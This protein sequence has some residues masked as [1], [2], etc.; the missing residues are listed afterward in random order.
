MPEHLADEE[1]VSVGLEMEAAGEVAAFGPERVPCTGLN[2]RQHPGAVQAGELHAAHTFLSSQRGEH[3]EEW[4]SGGE[5]GITEGG[6]DEDRR[7]RRVGDDVPKHLEAR[8]VR[9]LEVIEHEDEGVRGRHMLEEPGHGAVQEVAL[10]VG[11]RAHR[12]RDVAQ[13][14]AETGHDARQLPAVDRGMAFEFE[15][16]GVSDVVRKCLDEETV[17]DAEVLF[18]TSEEHDRTHFVGREGHLGLERGLAHSR[19]AGKEDHPASVA[20]DCTLQSLQESSGLRFA[21]DDAD[22][23][24]GLEAEGQGHPLR[25]QLVARRFPGHL[26][27]EHRVAQAL[28]GDFAQR[29]EAVGCSAPRRRPDQV[30]REDLAAI[31]LGAQPRRLDD[32]IAVVVTAFEGGLSRA[33]PDAQSHRASCRPVVPLDG[34]LHRHGT[35]QGTRGGRE[36]RH[37]AIS[38]QLHL[39]AAAPSDPL[40]E[41]GEVRLKQPVILLDAERHR[42]FG[43]TNDVGEKHRDVLCSGHFA[44]RPF[45][46]IGKCLGNAPHHR[47]FG[48]LDDTEIG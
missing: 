14:A 4:M 2:E 8:L 30:G 47:T 9:P 34:L 16:V 41:Q 39:C 42:Q 1:R 15:Y 10:G 6:K 32:R 21:A 19:L 35:R 27:S 17:G 22:G 24:P 43:R 40:A 12:G 23:Q 48:L 44:C 28:E 5:L 37:E 46:A 3:V 13:P 26:Q 25:G 38:E 33:D 36:D 29:D 18:A 11:V 45:R 31:G 7:F 20:G